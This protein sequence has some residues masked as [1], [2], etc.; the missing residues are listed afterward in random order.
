MMLALHTQYIKNQ[1]PNGMVKAGTRMIL[2]PI[3]L[4]SPGYERHY[5]IEL[6]R[7]AS[8]LCYGQLVMHYL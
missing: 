6:M 2:G 5:L 1:P 8:P 3:N 4:D 7:V